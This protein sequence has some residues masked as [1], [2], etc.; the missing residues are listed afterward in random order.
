MAQLIMILIVS[1][2]SQPPPKENEVWFLIVQHLLAN[3][4]VQSSQNK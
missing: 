4:V 3:V 1:I 2:N